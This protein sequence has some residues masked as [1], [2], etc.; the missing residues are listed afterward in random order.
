MSY[1]DLIAEQR[2]LVQ[3]DLA[4]VE[5]EADLWRARMDLDFLVGGAFLPTGPRKEER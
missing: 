1:L 3:T 5:A 4:L 2:N